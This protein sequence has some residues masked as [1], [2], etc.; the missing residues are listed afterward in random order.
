MDRYSKLLVVIL[1]VSIVGVFC[2]GVIDFQSAAALNLEFIP[3]GKTKYVTLVT[4]E[5]IVQVAPDNALHPGGI[6]YNAYTFN[7]TIPGP[8]IAIDQGDNLTITLVNDGSLIHSADFHA[9][10][11]DTHVD[12]GPVEPGQVHTWNLQGINGGAFMYHCA[13]DALNGIWE[14]IA[15]GMYGAIVVHPQNEA[16]AKEFYVSFG[17][18]YNTADQGLFMGT[19]GTVGLFDFTKF[20]TGQPDLILTNGMAHKYA[21][22]IG[23]ISKLELNPN[24]AVFSVRPGEPTRW[25]VLNPGPNDGVS[26]QFIGGQMDVRNGFSFNQTYGAQ[27][28][29]EETSWIPPGSA[30]VFETIF[31]EA[32]QYVGIDHAMVNVVKGAAF[33]VVASDSSTPPDHPEGTWVPPKGSDYVGGDQQAQ[34]VSEMESGGSGTS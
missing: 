31:T 17:E 4:N 32:G 8:V 20:V 3:N 16:P 19:N 21:P 12:S 5:T 1:I 6:E 9:G 33:V 15:N 11:G 30:S 34:W 29:N 18:I 26:F 13:A 22:A 25:Y 24:A 28:L 2:T 27:E 10:L 7:G 14:H 23:Q